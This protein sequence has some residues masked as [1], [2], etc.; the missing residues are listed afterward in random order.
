MDENITDIYELCNATNLT[1]VAV[2]SIC[3]TMVS[4]LASMLGATLIITSF[5]LW[6]DIRTTARAILVFLAIADLISA[7]GYTFAAILFLTN[8]DDNNIS[9]SLCTLQSF[10]TT[11]FPISSFLWTTSLAV[12]LFVSIT[13]RRARTAKKLMPLFH[14]VAWGIPLLLCI[15]GS[16]TMVLGTQTKVTASTQGTVDWCWVSFNNSFGTDSTIKDA[17]QRLV[18]LHWLELIFGK[19][20]EIMACT[21][22]LILCIIVKISLR[23]K[24][25]IN[26][27]TY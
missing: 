27:A 17:T 9:P 16:A 14:V 20:W 4:S 15:P 25:S 5:I 6:P 26:Y 1:L 23:K 11:A 21:I 18:M 8:N 2:G 12:Y 3:A 7:V 19:F 13:L 10:M 24:V 22:A